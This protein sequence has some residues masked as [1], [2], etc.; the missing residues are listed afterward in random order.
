MNSPQ[1][2]SDPT[3]ELPHMEPALLRKLIPV[4]RFQE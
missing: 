1:I 3:R 2:A 4:R